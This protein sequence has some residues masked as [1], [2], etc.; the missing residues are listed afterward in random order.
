[1]SAEIRELK[2]RIDVGIAAGQIS[3]NGG[4][5]RIEPCDIPNPKTG[6]LCPF[7][8]RKEGILC[9]QEDGLLPDE[10]IVFCP[11]QKGILRVVSM[12]PSE[13]Q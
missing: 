13:K 12:K 7:R 5:A 11:L 8:D 10:N 2:T 9:K 1:M 6:N 4:T 3:R